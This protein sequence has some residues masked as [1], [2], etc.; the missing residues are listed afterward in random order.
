MLLCFV[1]LKYWIL[2]RWGI[3]SIGLRN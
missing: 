2:F 3:Q 1:M